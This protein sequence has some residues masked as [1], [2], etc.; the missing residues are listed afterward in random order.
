MCILENVTRFELKYKLI[1]L[2]NPSHNFVLL[3]FCNNFLINIINYLAKNN[4]NFNIKFSHDSKV[5][6]KKEIKYEV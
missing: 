5:I 3:H 4:L 1:S 2:N 6:R